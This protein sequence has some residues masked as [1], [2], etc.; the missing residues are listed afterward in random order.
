M[1]SLKLLG[2]LMLCLVV[3]ACQQPGQNAYGAREVG[4]VALVQ[5]GVIIAQREVDVAAKNSGLGA[6]AGGAAGG[7]AVAA[8]GG[9]RGGA[10]AAVI[11]G[12]LIGALLEQMLA[13]RK[14]TE[15]IITLERG[16]T[17]TL[18]QDNQEGD[19]PLNV[20]D[21]VMVQVMGKTQRV[22]PA[23]ALPSEV[24]RPQGIKVTKGA[25]DPAKNRT[26]PVDADP[27]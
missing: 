21:R 8:S 20:G 2:T 19:A 7:G 23:A 12:A 9:S 11:G 6:V 17:I 14:A 26:R 1:K 5:F 10:A 15:F 16:H 18:V 3:S 25:I 24:Q 13:N 27:D 4:K 22:L